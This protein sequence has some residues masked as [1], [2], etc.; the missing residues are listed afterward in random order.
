MKRIKSKIIEGT[1]YDYQFDFCDLTNDGYLEIGHEENLNEYY[2]LKKD[3]DHY[4][5]RLYGLLETFRKRDILFYLEIIQLI[6]SNLPLKV[7]EI[8]DE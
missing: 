4:V 5:G 7:E 3:D 1:N 2:I 6:I 8:K